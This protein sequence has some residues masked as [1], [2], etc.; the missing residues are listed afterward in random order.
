[1]TPASR[2]AVV[3]AAFFVVPLVIFAVQVSLA[4]SMR[5]AD[6]R[7]VARQLAERGV[8]IDPSSPTIRP[9][10]SLPP[11]VVATWRA[12]R[13]G[14]VT[15]VEALQHR[16]LTQVVVVSGG[17]VDTAAWLR[18]PLAWL[19]RGPIFGTADD[20]VTIVDRAQ[21]YLAAQPLEGRP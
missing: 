12:G 1:M 5:E 19:W 15:L 13:H 16:R 11:R 9:Q 10:H 4:A 8:V 17:E 21:R 3:W 2:W 18:E 6:Q 7:H 14:S 20:A